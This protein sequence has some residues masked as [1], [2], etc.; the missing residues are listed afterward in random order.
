MIITQDAPC[1][2]HLSR[3]VK[4]CSGL[5]DET[6]FVYVVRLRTGSIAFFLQEI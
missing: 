5:Q 3:L 1:A 4:Q 6:D 2:A